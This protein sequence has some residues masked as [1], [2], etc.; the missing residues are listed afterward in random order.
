MV[1]LVAS[2]G[3]VALISD[4]VGPYIISASCGLHLQGYCGGN[5]SLD[6]EEFDTEANVTSDGTSESA[7]LLG[8][9]SGSE[10]P[11]TLTS[12]SPSLFVFFTSNDNAEGVGVRAAFSCS[13]GA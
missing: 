2:A 4:G 7:P 12:T 5:Y 3:I 11:P 9:F 10:L 13:G 1:A 8:R 6:F